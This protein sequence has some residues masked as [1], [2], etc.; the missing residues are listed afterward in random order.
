MPCRLRQLYLSPWPHLTLCLCARVRSGTPNRGYAAFCNGYAAAIGSEVHGGPAVFLLSQERLA[1]S[2]TAAAEV[3]RLAAFLE[4]ETYNVHR[5]RRP[6]TRSARVPP[7]WRLVYSHVKQTPCRVVAQAGLA[8]TTQVAAASKLADL[9][10][11]TAA[12][13]QACDATFAADLVDPRVVELFDTSDPTDVDTGAG[14][15]SFAQVW[16]LQSSGP[17]T[18]ILYTSFPHS[19]PRRTHQHSPALTSNANVAQ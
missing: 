1:N 5:P 17:R 4:V 12:Q 14:E 11:M 6:E 3:G 9:G 2:S 18:R 16:A 19:Q 15:D 8:A 13:A 7:A 10:V